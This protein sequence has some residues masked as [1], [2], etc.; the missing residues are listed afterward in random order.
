MRVRFIKLLGLL[1]LLFSQLVG[2][3]QCQHSLLSQ[4]DFGPH[5]DHDS[6]CN[7][8]LL[9]RVELESG[10]EELALLQGLDVLF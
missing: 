10:F 1:L 4:V 8:S 2:Y 6:L 9:I 7:L 5:F 3:F